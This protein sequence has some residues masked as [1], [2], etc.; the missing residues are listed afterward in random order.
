MAQHKYQINRFEHRPDADFDAQLEKV[1]DEF[2]ADGWELVHIMRRDK[3]PEDP[4]YGLIFKREKSEVG[5]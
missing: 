2:G 4:N 1:L 3:V 5:W